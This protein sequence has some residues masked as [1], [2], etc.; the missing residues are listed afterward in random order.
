MLAQDVRTRC[1]ARCPCGSQIKY[2]ISPI[3]N[4]QSPISPCPLLLYG[5]YT[6]W[7]QHIV[8]GPEHRTFYTLEGET[9]LVMTE[10]A[11]KKI[12]K[13]Q[14]KMKRKRAKKAAREAANRG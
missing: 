8:L 3:A 11:M 5:R 7:K 1:H 13:H 10:K 14:W 12:S 6:P 9:F 4:R 2:R